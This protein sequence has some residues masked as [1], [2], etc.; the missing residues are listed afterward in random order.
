M[1]FMLQDEGHWAFV[2]H[3]CIVAMLRMAARWDPHCRLDGID[4][5]GAIVMW[6]GCA[7]GH[8]GAND[9]L[10]GNARRKEA[11]QQ[12][13]KAGS[14]IRTVVKHSALEQC[15]NASSVVMKL[16]RAFAKGSTNVLFKRAGEV[17]ADHKRAQVDGCL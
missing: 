1:T 17:N 4:G 7:R 16:E 8:A 3:A 10:L 12:I 13:C 11:V 9:V 6:W 14:G 2:M 15:S 5:F